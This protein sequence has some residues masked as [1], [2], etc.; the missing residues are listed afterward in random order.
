MFNLERAILG[1]GGG[2]VAAD[3]RPAPMDRWKFICVKK[4]SGR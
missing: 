1:G 4:S 2:L 3:I